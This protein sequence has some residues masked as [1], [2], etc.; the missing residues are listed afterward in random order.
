MADK[1]I[2]TACTVEFGGVFHGPGFPLTLSDEDYR[3]MKAQ[4][5][6]VDAPKKKEKEKAT[7]PADTGQGDG[8]KKDGDPP[9][10]PHDTPPP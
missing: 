2:I 8:A 3:V 5:K 9:P 7:P 6:V 4:G 10:D 1:N